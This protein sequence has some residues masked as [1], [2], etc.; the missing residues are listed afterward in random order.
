VYL[1]G[2]DGFYIGGERTDPATCGPNSPF[3]WKLSNTET[4][5]MTY[6]NW[7]PGEPNCYWGSLKNCIQMWKIINYQWND[8][9]CQ[10]MMFSICEFDK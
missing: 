4:E 2:F 6:T 3:V 7:G 8:T 10:N 1:D 5:P 9:S